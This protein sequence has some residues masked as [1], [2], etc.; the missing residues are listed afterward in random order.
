MAGSPAH[1]KPVFV[2]IAGGTGAGKS[3][4][5][6]SLWDK[7]PE[8][9]GI[10]HLDDYFKQDG[11]VPLL[12][13]ME[14]WDHPNSLNLRKLA[15]D[16]EKLRHGEPIE[17]YTKHR[18]LDPNSKGEKRVWIEVTPKHVMLVEGYLVLHDEAVRKFFDT[19]IYLD[20]PHAVRYKR[21]V[22]FKIP[23]YEEK[24]LIPMHREYVEPTKRYAD[25]IINVE[26]LSKEKVARE[27]EGIV[28]RALKSRSGYA[29]DTPLFS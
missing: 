24:V 15:E 12:H 4:V 17:V 11:G 8:K 13:G 16:L 14:N 27:V 7:Y 9:I 26:K 6:Y 3:T 5:C 21:R 22:H 23:G 10:V 25:H 19:S 1:M 20:I 2:G 28:A 18:P 29:I